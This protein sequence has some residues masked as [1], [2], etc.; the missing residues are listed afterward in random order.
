MHFSHQANTSHEPGQHPP[1]GNRDEERW[2]I[3][4]RAAGARPVAAA[5]GA[6]G[7]RGYRRH[8]GGVGRHTY[9][10]TNAPVAAQSGV[11]AIAAGVLHTVAL[12]NDGSVLAW[13][14]NIYGQTNVPVSA[15]SGVTAI[16]AEAWHA[17]A[18][19]RGSLTFSV[20]D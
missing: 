2:R 19:K 7:E 1:F 3:L 6:D 5:G 16:A 20:G 4:W 8:D 13:G 18:L 15:Q 14:D 9:S 17:M 10:Q 12:K 11:T